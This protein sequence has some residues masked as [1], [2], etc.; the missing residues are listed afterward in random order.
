MPA[1]CWTRTAAES[2]LMR[3]P[4]RG[5]SGMFTSVDAVDA[6]LLRLFHECV[7][8]EPARRHELDRDDEL[9]ARQ[10]VCHARFFGPRDRR[11]RSARSQ[12]SSRCAQRADSSARRGKPAHRHL[13]MPDVL[14]R[15][16][17]AAADEA[18]A[19]VDEAP[20]VRR[21]VLGRTEID[22]PA[23]D[24]ARLAGVGL[25]GELDRRDAR[26]PLD[27]FEHRRRARRCS[28]ARRPAH[29]ARSSSGTNASGAAPS[30]LLPS[31]SVVTWA[32]IGRSQ[33]L[34]TARIAAP[35]SFTSRKVSSTNRSTPPSSSPRACSRKNS[36]ASSTPVLP[37]GSMRMPSG[38]IAPAT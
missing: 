15:R 10:R 13:D 1:C 3:A 9:A 30:R 2:A 16:P 11:R 14:R 6:E 34:R 36:S 28:S 5:P 29:R 32:T 8:A 7:G 18:H 4:A 25:R 33:R 12:S 26:H 21:H 23:F 17:A 20:R 31:S 27:R 24:L 19:A 38:P 37:Q 35:I 22:V